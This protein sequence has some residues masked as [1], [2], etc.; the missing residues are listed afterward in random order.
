MNNFKKYLESKE[1]QNSLNQL[2]KITPE[3]VRHSLSKE[4]VDSTDFL[5][6]ISP[7]A[8]EVLEEMARKAHDITTKQFGKNILLYTPIYIS[9]YCDNLCI[10]CGFNCD[11]KTKR[12]KLT[13]EEIQKELGAIYQMGFRDILILTGESLVHANTKYIKEAV[14]MARKKFKSVSI[15]VYPMTEREYISIKESGCNGLTLYQETYHKEVYKT[16]HLKGPKSNYEFRLDAPERAARAG[17]NQ[18]NIGALL[19]L[20]DPNYDAICLYH[21]LKYLEK[22][23]PFIELGASFPRI[24]EVEGSFFTNQIAVSD[25]QFV[26]Y[27][28]AFRLCFH[29]LSIAISTRENSYLREKLIPLGINK[30]SAN[31][32][33]AVGG[34]SVY[35]DS[36]PQF[37]ISD[38]S[39]IKDVINMIT[40]NGYQVLYSDWIA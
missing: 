39:S 29:R 2:S 12:T 17:F 32:S 33:T 4:Y 6:F 22:N 24:K 27:I 1:I 11:N 31:V 8:D 20:Y 9:D 23:Y 26:K 30:M 3:D 34:H 14:K 36:T 13:G 19:G 40:R 35:K 37:D 7:A 25:K 5:H 21:H 15:E 28:L 16:L 38:E 10:Y 18:I